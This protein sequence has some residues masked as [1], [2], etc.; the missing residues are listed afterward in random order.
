MILQEVFLAGLKASSDE[1]FGGQKGHTKNAY[2]VPCDMGESLGMRTCRLWEDEGCRFQ[3]DRVN[4]P[5]PG[6]RKGQMAIC[7]MLVGP[8]MVGSR[9]LVATIDKHSHHKDVMC[10]PLWMRVVYT[11]FAK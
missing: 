11:T 10:V 1:V 2:S 7:I 9:K 8:S 4:A 5:I 6:L 3:P